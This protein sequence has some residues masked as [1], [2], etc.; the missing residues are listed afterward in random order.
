[1]NEFN[2]QLIQESLLQSKHALFEANR[3]A[4][5]NRDL[6]ALIAI[7]D[8][9]TVLAGRVKELDSNGKYMVGFTSSVDEQGDDNE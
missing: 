2:K 7:S 4:K 8:R 5:M 6:E 1:M 9:W 3:I